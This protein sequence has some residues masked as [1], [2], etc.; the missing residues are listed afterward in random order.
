MTAAP[1][2]DLTTV[3][4]LSVCTCVVAGVGALPLGTLGIT[5]TF[6]LDLLLLDGVAVA[7]LPVDDYGWEGGAPG[8]MQTC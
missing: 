6:D 8:R 2:A 5:L 4:A 7:G 1:V 3:A